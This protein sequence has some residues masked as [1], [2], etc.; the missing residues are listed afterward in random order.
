M[1]CLIEPKKPV[2]ACIIVN[3]LKEPYKA[4]G[5]YITVPGVVDRFEVVALSPNLLRVSWE[6][7]LSPNGILTGYQVEVVNLI[8]STDLLYLMAEDMQQHNISNGISKINRM[9]KKFGCFY[10]Y[11]A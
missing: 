2:N 7:P 3:I 1:K 8:D 5:L 11:V 10:N 4:Y 9:Y 6:P